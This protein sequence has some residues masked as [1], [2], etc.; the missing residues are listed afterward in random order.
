VLHEYGIGGR[1][2]TALL[3]P[4]DNPAHI[5]HRVAGRGDENRPAIELPIQRLSTVMRKLGHSRITL[6]K[7]DVE[8]A[9]Y[10]VISDL[11]E[12]KID[13][14]QLV[15][16]FHHQLKGYGLRDTEAA[17]SGLNRAGYRV[18]H[19]SQTGREYSFLRTPT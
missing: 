16:E 8:G 9:E 10:S 7:L 4:P 19:V 14:A 1:D 12:L 18:F 3:V 13:V 17:I 2:G 6:L 15:L 11:L 5:S